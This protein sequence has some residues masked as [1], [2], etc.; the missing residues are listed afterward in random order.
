[1]KSLIATTEY[2]TTALEITE[3]LQILSLQEKFKDESN[4]PE[5]VLEFIKTEV[6]ETSLQSLIQDRPHW[7]DL[8][9]LFPGL[10]NAPAAKHTSKKKYGR[11]NGAGKVKADEILN[12]NNSPI[13]FKTTMSG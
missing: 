12:N 2:K 3:V 4:E 8:L 13:S 9:E 11:Y 7:K 1:M 5:V 6:N 10:K